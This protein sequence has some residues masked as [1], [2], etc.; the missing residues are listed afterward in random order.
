LDN[1]SKSKFRGVG[2][3]DLQM[4]ANRTFRIED[5]T[6]RLEERDFVF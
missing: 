6:L 2:L 3:R 1:G 5:P 4:C